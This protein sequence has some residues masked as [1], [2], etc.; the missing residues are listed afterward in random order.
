MDYDHREQQRPMERFSNSGK[1][2]TTTSD[3]PLLLQYSRMYFNHVWICFCRVSGLGCKLGVNPIC[4]HPR[5]KRR[6]AVVGRVT[7]VPAIHFH[8]QFAFS[9][10][11]AQPK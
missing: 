11:L 1:L 10:V 4:A 8:F 3:T 6:E 2:S 5:E 7:D 9:C